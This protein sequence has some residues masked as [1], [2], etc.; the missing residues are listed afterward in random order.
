M[1]QS[2]LQVVLEWVLDADQ[3]LFYR[4]FGALGIRLFLEL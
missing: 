3:H 4:V 1:F 2:L